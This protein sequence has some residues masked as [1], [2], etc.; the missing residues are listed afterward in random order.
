VAGRSRRHTVTVRCPRT[1]SAIIAGRLGALAA[2]LAALTVAGCSSMSAAVHST[3][4][5]R[6]AG[7]TRQPNPAG[8]TR[9]QIALATHIARHEIARL[10]AHIR[11]AVAQ[12]HPGVVLS[13]S[14]T[15]H[16]CNSGTLL[17]V[18]LIGSFPNTKVSP[19]PGGDATVHAEL[20]VADPSTGEEC[21]IGVQTGQVQRPDGATGLVVVAQPPTSEHAGM[22]ALDQ[23]R[24]LSPLAV[25]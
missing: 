6:P 14:N 2:C 13:Q 11:I 18:T 4:H 21:L 3:R 1:K 10:E 24:P 9:H 17:R 22:R 19:N 25:G 16:T 15:G 8:L 12:L 7:L 5:S 20:V 23:P